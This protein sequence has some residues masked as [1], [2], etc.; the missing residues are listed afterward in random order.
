MAVRTGVDSPR[1]FW[2][3]DFG[4]RGHWQVVL[5]GVL[6][7]VSIAMLI[8]KCAAASFLRGGTPVPTTENPPV[9]EKV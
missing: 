2:E 6:S 8:F 7:R 4:R 9:S 3:A 5:S 1:K